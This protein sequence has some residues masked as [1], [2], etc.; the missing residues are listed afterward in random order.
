MWKVNPASPAA[1]LSRSIY[2]VSPW[3]LVLM[4]GFRP[5]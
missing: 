4:I 3:P 5:R 1:F 2:G